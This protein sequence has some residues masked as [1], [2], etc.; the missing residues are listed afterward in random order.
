MIEP[1][2]K[3]I[4][5][6]VMVWDKFRSKMVPATLTGFSKEYIFTT[7]SADVKKVRAS[8]AWARSGGK[9]RVEWAS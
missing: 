1:T 6:A 7:E 5:R 8:K 2:K 3:D 4:G 9:G